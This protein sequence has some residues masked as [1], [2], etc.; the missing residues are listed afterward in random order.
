MNRWLIKSDPGDFGL[1][2][3]IEAGREMWDG[4]RNNTALM[5]LRA[6][7][8]GDRVLVYHSGKEKAV[9]GEARVLK[10]PYPDPGGDDPR[11][12]VVDLGGAKALRRPVALPE[13]KAAPSL[14]EMPLLKIS[15]LSVM[16]VQEDEWDEILRLSKSPSP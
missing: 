11:F 2:D 9:V 4:V 1:S 8:R 12:V 3:L 15:R 14:Q 6:M 13:I 5:H 10:A 7:K 16:P